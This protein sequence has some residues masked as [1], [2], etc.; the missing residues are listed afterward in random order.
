MDW[1]TSAVA[2]CKLQWGTSLCESLPEELPDTGREA[3]FSCTLRHPSHHRTH[4][5]SRALK[6]VK[7]DFNKYLLIFS[8]DFPAPQGAG[9]RPHSVRGGEQAELQLWLRCR[10][11]YRDEIRGRSTNG[12][13]YRW[14]VLTMI[15]AR[16][17]EGE[18]CQFESPIDFELHRSTSLTRCQ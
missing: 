6:R 15:D 18:Q 2:I 1:S 14:E 8:C 12:N 4:H 9:L 17:C 7:R 10:A 11:R 3:L 5:H 13:R 16:A